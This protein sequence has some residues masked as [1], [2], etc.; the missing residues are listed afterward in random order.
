MNILRREVPM[1]PPSQRRAKAT[2]E[3]RRL[4]L[5]AAKELYLEHGSANPSSRLLA[6][7]AGVAEGTVFAHFP[8]KATLLAAALHDDLEEALST[9]R[10]TL[11][12]DASCREKLLRV[13]AALYAYYAKRPAL[14]RALV[15]ES[16]FLGGEWGW[17]V[18]ETVQRFTG[19]AAGL[20]EDAKAAGEYA[21]DADA[22]AFAKAFFSAYFFE[23][24]SALSVEPY[25]ELG[26]VQALDA[27]LAFLE[28]GMKRG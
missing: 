21:R 15:R 18:A 22:A 13:A 11:P 12:D 2:A 6:E 23:L 3:T 16:L 25:N 26:A 9:A 10:A 24:V 8:D 7:R 20:A 28:R 5:A 4:I 19:Y 1:T 27:Q 17:R 14:S